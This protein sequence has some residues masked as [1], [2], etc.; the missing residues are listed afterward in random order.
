MIHANLDGSKDG[1]EVDNKNVFN[2]FF[3]LAE[4]RFLPGVVLGNLLE[5]IGYN[6]PAGLM[7]YYVMREIIMKTAVELFSC[8]YSEP[9]RKS[10]MAFLA[11][12][13]EDNEAAEI[14]AHYAGL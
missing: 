8:N 10:E 2:R 5:D 12:M 6:N 9:G 3:G 11:G 14:I 7:V 4:R 1:E 13:K